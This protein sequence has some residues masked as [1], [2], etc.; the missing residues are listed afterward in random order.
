MHIRMPVV[1]GKG[2]VI[3]LFAF[4]VLWLVCFFI[5]FMI[6]FGNPSTESGAILKML[7]LFFVI[8][9]P[10]WGVPAAL[11]LGALF[12][13][14]KGLTGLLRKQDLPSDTP[15]CTRQLQV[16]SCTEGQDGAGPRS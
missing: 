13:R 2:A 7:E 6:A 12:I 3:G 5:A 8:A 9:N 15:A 4:A 14:V 10:L 16:R 1:N 11:V